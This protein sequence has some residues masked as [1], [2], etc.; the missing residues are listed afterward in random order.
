MN[1]VGMTARQLHLMVFVQS[2][3]AEHGYSPNYSEIA[4]GIQLASRGNIAR[5]IYALEQRGY[6]RRLPRQARSLM[7]SD[8]GAV[9]AQ[10]FA[11]RSVSHGAAA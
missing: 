9:V 1:P 5:L 10:R 11:E 7:L 2:Y 3:I 4:A 8:E 6:V